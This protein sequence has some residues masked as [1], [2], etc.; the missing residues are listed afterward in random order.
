MKTNIAKQNLWHEIIK[1]FNSHLSVKKKEERSDFIT[2]G[3]LKIAKMSK[4]K[5]CLRTKKRQIGPKGVS[6]MTDI[7]EANQTIQGMIP[8]E[9]VELVYPF[10]G[11]NVLQAPIPLVLIT[12]LWH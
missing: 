12:V 11:D 6:T 7:D 3:V 4:S 10:N 5:R 8:G 2:E 1:K 9:F